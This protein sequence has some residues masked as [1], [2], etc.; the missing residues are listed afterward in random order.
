MLA[1]N[2]LDIVFANRMHVGVEMPGIST[3]I[4]GIELHDAERF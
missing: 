2:L 3:P 4:I 1:L